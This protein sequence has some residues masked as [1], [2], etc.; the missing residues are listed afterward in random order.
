MAGRARLKRP[1]QAMAEGTIAPKVL[2]LWAAQRSRLG[3]P[4]PSGPVTALQRGRLQRGDVRP[5]YCVQQFF[6]RWA[7][8][9]RQGRLREV[10]AV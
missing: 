2:D 1:W 3:R 6:D 5:H 8:L 4:Q 10:T 9:G 7:G